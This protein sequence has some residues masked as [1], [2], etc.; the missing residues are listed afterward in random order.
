MARIGTYISR[1]VFCPFSNR[2]GQWFWDDGEL[3]PTLSASRLYMICQ[4]REL[5]FEN[6]R[7]E[8]LDLTLQFDLVCGDQF[9]RNVRV[10][11]LQFSS[12]D[13]ATVTVEGGPKIIRIFEQRSGESEKALRYWFTPDKLLFHFWRNEIEVQNLPEFR[14]FLDFHLHYVGISK[15]HDSFQRLYET[16]HKGRS[17]IMTLESSLRSG[18]NLSDELTMLLFD[19]EVNEIQTHSGTDD[20]IDD[21]FASTPQPSSVIAD[22]EKAFV[23]VLD[24]KYCDQK[25]RKYPL[26]IDGLS[27]AGLTRYFFI[28]SDPLTLRT[29][30]AQLHGGDFYEQDRQKAA[31]S[32]SVEGTEVKMNTFRSGG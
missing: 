20:D 3:K 27:N 6:L 10:P 16:A 24:P 11:L 30:K 14:Q 22:A 21:L 18:A 31:D 4:R 1:L 9:A 29:A 17:K 12:K 23:K 19:V 2:E 13:E 5:F 26:S 32:I 8:L 7:P 28:I 25:Y 15:D